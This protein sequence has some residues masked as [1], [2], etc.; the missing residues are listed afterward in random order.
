MRGVLLFLFCFLRVCLFFLRTPP[1]NSVEYEEG[2]HVNT[3]SSGFVH[4]IVK[5]I[6]NYYTQ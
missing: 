1:D 3:E 4:D 2:F 6:G 5:N